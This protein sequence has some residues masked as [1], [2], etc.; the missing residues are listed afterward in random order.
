MNKELKILAIVAFFTV[1]LYIGVEPYAHS[2][3]HKHVEGQNFVYDGTADIEEASA[4]KKEVKKKFWAEVKTI[5]ELKGDASAGEATFAMCAGCHME[6]ATN[7][8]G[9]TPPSLD[10]AGA[11]YDKNYL[12]ALIKDPAMASNVDHKYPDGT[13]SHPMGSISTMVTEPQDIAN[14]VAYL[15]EKKAGEVTP[16]EAFEEA[17]MRCHANRYGGLTQL[18]T[19]PKTKENIKTGQDIEAMKFAQKV[20]EEQGAIAEYMGKLPPDLSII[21]RARSEHF[22][23]TFVENPQSQLAGTAMPRVGLNE[24]GYEKVIEYLAETGDPSAK[25]RAELG[26]WV[27][28]FFVIF[29]ILAYL[30]K[31]SLWRDLH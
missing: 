11:I 1:L 14:V 4:D 16:K 26:P 31:S 18:G 19:A 30:W 2:Q 29:T 10:H 23:E 28:G 17:C 15:K 13:M 12:I 3:M 7:M 9:V 25:A 24:E 6:G 21:Y 8:G 20:A 27:I 22:L 5:A